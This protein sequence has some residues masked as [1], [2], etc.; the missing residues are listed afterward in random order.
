MDQRKSTKERVG[1]ELD[2]GGGQPRGKQTMGNVETRGVKYKGGAIAG[3]PKTLLKGER[4]PMRGAQGK[5]E[6]F[7]SDARSKCTLG[8]R[9]HHKIMDG[10]GE[11][12]SGK[13]L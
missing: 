4:P 9:S 6:G 12:L 3:K 2:S 8:S 1:K 11:N 5:S 13:N 10:R 7:H